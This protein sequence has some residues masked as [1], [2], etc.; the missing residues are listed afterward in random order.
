[1]SDTTNATNSNITIAEDKTADNTTAITK[2]TKISTILGVDLDPVDAGYLALKK[3]A[4]E[5]ADEV[6]FSEEGPAITF[7]VDDMTFKVRADTDEDFNTVY[8]S[9]ATTYFPTTT[10][11]E[12]DYVGS[13]DEAIFALAEFCQNDF[14]EAA[15]DEYGDE[16]SSDDADEDVSE[17]AEYEGDED[18]ADDTEADAKTA[19]EGAGK[20]VTF[21]KNAMKK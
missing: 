13:I 9:T 1:M 2:D 6:V 16:S 4:E 10:V 19:E 8:Q 11:F 17:S 20:T 15:N 7:S 3:F 21:L 5:H 18:G 12:S 14:V